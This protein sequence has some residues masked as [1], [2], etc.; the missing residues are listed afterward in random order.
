M[1]CCDSVF[2]NLTYILYHIF[3]KKSSKNFFSHLLFFKTKMVVLVF[4]DQFS[5][6]C[7]RNFRDKYI[8]SLLRKFLNSINKINGS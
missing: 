5:N 2:I 1:I 6:R 3:F 4:F 8:T 7:D